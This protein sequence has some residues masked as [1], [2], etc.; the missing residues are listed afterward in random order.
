MLVLA[1][2]LLVLPGVARAQS[3]AAQASHLRGEVASVLD[4]HAPGRDIVRW[5]VLDGH[6]KRHR[7]THAQLIRYRDVLA[8]MLAGPTPSSSTSVS[9]LASTTAGS[10]SS[11]AQTAS[12]AAVASGGSSSGDLPTCTW[13][14]ESGGDW[15]AVNPS[16]RAGGRY[17]IMPSTWTANGGTGL[18]QD[19]S[20]AE[21]TRVAENILRSQGSGAWANC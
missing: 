8:R 20:P 1:T 4:K 21:Q 10:S 5:G 6:G 9:S 11:S 14:P 17:Q 3:L 15:N 19:A 13:V 16:S 12:Q 18:P 7:A 2:G